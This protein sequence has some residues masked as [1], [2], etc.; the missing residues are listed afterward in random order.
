LAAAHDGDGFAVLLLEFAHFGGDIVP[1]QVRIAPGE[2][3]AQERD[4]TY[5]GLR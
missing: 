1:N 3:F 4:T 2:R 5:F